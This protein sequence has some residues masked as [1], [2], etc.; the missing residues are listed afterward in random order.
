MDA[1]QQAEAILKS[2]FSR[3][4]N[5]ATQHVRARSNVHPL[6]ERDLQFLDELEPAV[7]ALLEHGSTEVDGEE[8]VLVRKEYLD[9]LRK[10]VEGDG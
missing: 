2:A 3:Y 7:D 4:D 1:L 5:A 8:V 6:I 9:A 10:V